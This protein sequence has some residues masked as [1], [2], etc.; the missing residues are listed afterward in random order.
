MI[1]NPPETLGRQFS[2]VSVNKLKPNLLTEFDCI[3]T[4][5]N[6]LLVSNETLV[7]FGVFVAMIYASI[8][9]MK[10]LHYH[11]IPDSLF[12]NA[13]QNRFFRNDSA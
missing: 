3:H 5:P 13:V 7:G 12:V 1:N 8:I 10:T 6:Y 9:M 2:I 11:T 4:K